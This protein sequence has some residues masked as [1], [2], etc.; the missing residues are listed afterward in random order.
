MEFYEVVRARQSVREFKPDAVPAEVLLRLLEA[1]R[2][3][4]SWANV[5]PWEM[6]LVQDMLLPLVLSGWQD[7]SESLI[8][9]IV[10]FCLK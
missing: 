7:P 6:I 1:F 10:S 2:A 3:A 9:T 4:P 5:Q 8:D